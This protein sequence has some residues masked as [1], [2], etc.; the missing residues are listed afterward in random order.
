MA[1]IS[2]SLWMIGASNVS[3]AIHT[4]SCRGTGLSDAP[5][6]ET[7]VAAENKKA[8]TMISDSVHLKQIFF[9]I[10]FTKPAETRQF[11]S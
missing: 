10:V 2:A 4:N 5:A 9:I 8:V 7:A 11:L 1:L 3:A 6:S